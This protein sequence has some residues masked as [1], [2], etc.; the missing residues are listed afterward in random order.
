MSDI[1][2]IIKK[3]SD[4]MTE[5]GTI[6]NILKEKF[7]KYVEEAIEDSFKWGDLKH[8][9]EN[10]VKETMVPYIEAYDFSKYLP[11]LDSVLTD[12]VNSTN[13]KQNR[14][15]L[16]NFK[17]LM[18]EP[19]FKT[20][21]VSEI[22]KKYKEFVSQN[23]S[24]SG[25]EVISDFDH[26]CY[27]PM[28]VYLEIEDDSSN[29]WSS[30]DRKNFTLAIDES[31]DDDEQNKL[32]VSLRLSRWKD[33]SDD[34]YKVSLMDFNPIPGGVRLDTLKHLS[35]FEVFL[36]TLQRNY[37]GIEIDVTEDSD[38]VYSDEEPEP[39]YS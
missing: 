9:I 30:Y 28:E 23:M 27:E 13:I 35:K 11:K 24:T 39:S 7:R 32:N 5:D 37:I 10:H 26:P 4:E 6:E 25:R 1:T 17:E 15:I 12:I 22:F 18:I 34:T 3:V 19:D 20:I 2:E 16:N 21:K 31:E 14:D 38:E 29:K 33:S 36:L 8:A